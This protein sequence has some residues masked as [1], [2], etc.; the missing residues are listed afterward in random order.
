M[1]DDCL[2]EPSAGFQFFNSGNDKWIKIREG[3]S[4]QT[5]KLINNVTGDC[6]VMK[7]EDLFGEIEM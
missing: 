1:I 6:D 5:G 3:K 4:N 7:V 2:S